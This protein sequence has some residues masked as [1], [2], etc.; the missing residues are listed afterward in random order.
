MK[1]IKKE[2]EK[3]RD[4]L[5]QKD[6]TTKTMSTFVIVVLIVLVIA[7]VASGVYFMNN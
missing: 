7:V 3:S 1:F 6:D 2:D 4:Y 5:L